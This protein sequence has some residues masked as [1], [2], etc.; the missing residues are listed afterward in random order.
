MIENFDAL[1]K[2]VVQA[3]G[4]AKALQKG[5]TR[6]R[7]PD[8]S[9]ITEA[10]CIVNEMIQ[11]SIHTL[12]PQ[13]V[14]ISEESLFEGNTDG[15]LIFVLDPIDGTDV[16]SQ[17][18]PGWCVALGVLNRDKQPIGS[19][20]YAPNLGTDSSGILLTSQEGDTPT[21]QGEPLLPPTVVIEDAQ[22][23]AGSRAHSHFILSKYP[24][25][26][27]NIGSNIL[28]MVAPLIY[29]NSGGALI[30]G[31]F[32]WDILPAHHILSSLGLEILSL[33]EGKPMNYEQD[34]F[35]YRKA[36]LIDGYLS[37]S[38]EYIKFA[39]NHIFLAN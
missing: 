16:F 38:M 35:L 39:R 20:I 29:S 25:K 15:E 24:Q 34:E 26:I 23:M 12:F 18:M 36:P 6:N 2:A 5:I 9:I 21:I 32:V 11:Q 19:I 37:G 3:G 30:H 31:C 1:I 33:L 7:K 13:A 28:H 27:R 14:C 8:G 4:V 17:G 22:L 10:D